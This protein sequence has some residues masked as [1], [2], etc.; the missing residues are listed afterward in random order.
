MAD[1]IQ[2]G[3]LREVADPRAPVL[4]AVGAAAHPVRGKRTPSGLGKKVHKWSAQAWDTSLQ[5]IDTGHRYLPGVFISV[6]AINMRF[7]KS[8]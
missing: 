4:R 3:H 2:L 6:T 8:G 5:D 1:D 7:F